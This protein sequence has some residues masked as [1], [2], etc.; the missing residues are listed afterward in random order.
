MVTISV[1]TVRWL[2]VA[3]IVKPVAATSTAHETPKITT[4]TYT[5]TV[6]ILIAKAMQHVPWAHHA[7][8]L[9]VRHG[10]TQRA[11]AAIVNSAMM[12]WKM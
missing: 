2:R 4:A 11:V 5:P 10:K 9:S 1:M 7:A 3:V 8:M 12:V 6:L